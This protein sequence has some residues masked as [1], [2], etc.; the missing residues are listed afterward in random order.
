MPESKRHLW[1]NLSP[2]KVA[3]ILRTDLERGLSEKE[4]RIRQKK[5][6]L[7]KLPEEKPLPSK[8]L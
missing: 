4:I 2:E 5:F 3:E 8:V 1:H 7:N 6:G